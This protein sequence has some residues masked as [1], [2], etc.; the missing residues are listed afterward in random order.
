MI[1]FLSG[2]AGTLSLI[3]GVR[4]ILYDSEIAVVAN[5][6][7]DLWI[8]GGHCAPDIDTAV[9]L[10]AG[11]LDTGRWWGIKG[12]TYATHNYLPKV[13]GG[14]PFPVG[15]RA[16]AVQIAR[17]ALLNEGL[18]LTEAVER[19]CRSL[20]IGATVLPMTDGDA[21]LFVDTGTERIPLLTYRMA[22]DPG[23]EVRELVRPVPPA[24]TDRVRAAIEESDA[25]VI[26]PANPAA[27]ILPILDC[28][29]MRDLLRDAF[30]VAVSPF[31]GG[32][33]PDP[34]DAALMYAVG[35]PPTSPAVS[36]LYGNIVDVFV[37]DIHDPD[38]VPG[39][40][41]LETR[42]LHERQA[43]SLAW[44]ITAVIRHAVS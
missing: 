4:Q 30:V 34:K 15:D 29:G 5:T 26:G 35:E 19:Q 23:T 38:D 10:F 12:D 20:K 25:V 24:V 28:A 6:A 43:E 14:E 18:T 3:R 27:S 39:S 32:A 31:R 41:R 42:L 40:L 9:F 22:A 33:T 1:T 16:R 8:S 11:I 17:A 2:G 21:A 44:D 7:E 36:R 37:Q 13:A